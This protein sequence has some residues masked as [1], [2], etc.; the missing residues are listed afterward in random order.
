MPKLR[1]VKIP[2]KIFIHLYADR[3][4]S[5]LRLNEVS[6]YLQNVLGKR[7]VIDVRGDFI[8]YHFGD[9]ALGRR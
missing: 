9:S 6:D 7:A 1:I 2:E 4:H 3:P 8:K 5:N